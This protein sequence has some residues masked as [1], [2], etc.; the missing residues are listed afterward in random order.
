MKSLRVRSRL[1]AYQSQNGK[2]HYC[3]VQM[4]LSSPDQLDA[5]PNSP[6]QV[7]RLKCTAEHLIPRSEGGSD[8]AANIAAACRHCNETRHRM[9]PPPDA[10][11]YRAIVTTQV[12]N[13][14]WHSRRIRTL[15]LLG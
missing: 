2:C 6:K 5:S 11:S 14:V 8:G 15:G 1:A 10:T 13:G 12:R 7:K 3:G 4:W 9:Q